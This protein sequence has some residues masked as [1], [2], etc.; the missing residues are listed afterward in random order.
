[1]P[2]APVAQAAQLYKSHLGVIGVTLPQRRDQRLMGL[3][4]GFA[5]VVGAEPLAVVAVVPGACA[6][7]S[8]VEPLGD[9]HMPLPGGG[10]GHQPQDQPHTIRPPLGKVAARLQ[11]GK[12]VFPLPGFQLVPVHRHIG[13]AQ[14]GVLAVV[15]APGHQPFHGVGDRLVPRRNFGRRQR[16]AHPQ[17][18]RDQQRRPQQQQRHPFAGLHQASRLPRYSTSVTSCTPSMF[19]TGWVTL[20]LSVLR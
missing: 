9:I 13:K 7:H 10:V 4:E 1:M 6:A 18:R 19:C 2:L 15:F 16:N 5:G 3:T 17:Q 8:I 20:R 14:V 12:I 11:G